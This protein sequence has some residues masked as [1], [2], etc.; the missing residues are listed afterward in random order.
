[1]GRNH[2]RMIAQDDWTG[3]GRLLNVTQ[4]SGNTPVLVTHGTFSNADTC[5]PLAAT[6]GAAHPAYVLEWRGRDLRLGRRQRFDYTSLAD[7]EM[8]MAI[9]HL[10]S[11]YPKVHLVAHSGGGLALALA[12]ARHPDLRGVVSSL[13]VM[14]AQATRLRDAPQKFQR[15]MRRAAWIGRRLGYWPHKV[16]KV[17][18]VSESA[19]LMEQWLRWNSQGEMADDRG[20]LR[21]RLSRLNLPVLVLAGAGDRLIAPPEGCRDYAQMFGQSAELELCGTQTGYAENYNHARMIRS[22]TAVTDLWP[23]IARWLDDID[24]AAPAAYPVTA[25]AANR[26]TIS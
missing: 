25:D 20:P 23:R 17:G 10:A 3:P 22:R 19:Q 12:V 13:T 8:T 2:D 7:G 1:M 6:L 11:R 16:I 14:G 15:A 18:P 24:A 4:A 5:A 9:R 21:T 26:E